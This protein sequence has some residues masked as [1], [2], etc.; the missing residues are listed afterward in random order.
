MEVTS[1]VSNVPVLE[2]PTSPAPCSG[3]PG[4]T[5]PEDLSAGKTYFLYYEYKEKKCKIIQLIQKQTS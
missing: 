2:K 4:L 1:S 5:S 3:P